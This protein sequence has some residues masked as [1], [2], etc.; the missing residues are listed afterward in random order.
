M[1]LSEHRFS[2]AH[3]LGSTIE[4]S[5]YNLES[6]LIQLQNELGSTIEESE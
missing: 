5:E 2:Y 3:Q 1:F 6:E 4:E